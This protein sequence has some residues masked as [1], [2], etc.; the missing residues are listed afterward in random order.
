MMSQEKPR[1]FVAL[2]IEVWAT[3]RTGL[4]RRKSPFCQPFC[5]KITL[6]EVGTSRC[7]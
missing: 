1:M 6:L 2:P 7:N 5:Q 4:W 3:S